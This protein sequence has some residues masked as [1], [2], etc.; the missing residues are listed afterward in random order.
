MK[1]ILFLFTLFLVVST[2]T[3][4]QSNLSYENLNTIKQ[5]E[6]KIKGYSEEMINDSHWYMRFLADSLF[7]RGFVKALKINN[8]FDYPFDSITSVSKL[9]APDSSFRIFTWQM[10]RDYTYYRQRGAIQIH[11]D[12]GSLKL[13]PLF[14]VS[15]FT[16]SPTDS[17]RDPKNWIGAIYYKILMNTVGNKK[18]FT[19]LGYD[20]NGPRSNK[21]WIDILTFDETGKPQFGGNYF[22]FEPD[23]IK[24]KK[25][26]LRYCV[27]YKKESKM[28][29]L[30]D[31]EEQMIIFDHLISENDEPENLY[32][33][34][35]DGSYEGF[36]WK[37][38]HWEHVAKLA[39][40]FLGNGNAPLPSMLLDKE[41]NIDQKKLEE[42]SKKNLLL[43]EEEIK[44]NSD[45]KVEPKKAKKVKFPTPSKLPN[46]MNEY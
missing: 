11:T 19:L 12:D 33:Y 5:Q 39:T 42:M 44:E 6:N 18:V 41:G 22:K 24:N 32:T 40:Q 26:T 38:N 13:Y 9:Y 3:L 35:P 34:I 16:T 23:T 8:S 29:V 45:K 31:K 15:D 4:G 1:Q 27:E 21:K 7:T 37:D 28:R 20:E 2:Y 17:I 30:F 14:D 36:K 10:M 46:D 25:P 43:Q